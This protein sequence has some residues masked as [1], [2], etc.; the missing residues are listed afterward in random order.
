V[1]GQHWPLVEQVF[2]E[3]AYNLLLRAPISLQLGKNV[4]DNFVRL[5]SND[6]SHVLEEVSREG[7]TSTSSRHRF[8]IIRSK[9]TR[10]I[11]NL[12]LVAYHPSY[13]YYLGG[14]IYQSIMTDVIW[15]SVAVLSGIEIECAPW[16]TH[17]KSRMVIERDIEHI[18]RASMAG[19]AQQRA[20]W[21]P[22][23]KKAREASFKARTER[24]FPELA[25]A[26]ANQAAAGYPNLQ[27]SWENQAAKG[28]PNLVKAKEAN[29]RKAAEVRRLRIDALCQSLEVR[30]FLAK[31][32]PVD[33]AKARVFDMWERLVART[34]PRQVTVYLYKSG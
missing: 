14:S 12:V 13:A 18:M 17:K 7:I 9:A 11:T 25:K 10:R 31:G 21:F 5:L 16:F 30:E 24:G 6:K 22:N 15:N 20:A 8:Y 26:R 33:N 32:R 27:K 23:I 1:F 2:A 34:R 28:Y 4:E 3:F 29:S 19:A